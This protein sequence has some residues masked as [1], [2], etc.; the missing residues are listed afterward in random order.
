MTS[1]IEN[2][3]FSKL[4]M[5]TEQ[6]AIMNY[7]PISVS[8]CVDPGD[9]VGTVMGRRTR[10]GNQV[11][12]PRVATWQPNAATYCGSAPLLQSAPWFRLLRPLSLHL[13]FY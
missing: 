13:M 12:Q 1:I 11:W 8:R 4:N 2:V 9:D 6:K 7:D 10:S 5:I 3:F